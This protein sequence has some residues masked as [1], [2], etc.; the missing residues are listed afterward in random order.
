MAP[1][2]K[3]CAGDATTVKRQR[4]VMSLSSKIELLDWF[5]RGETTASIG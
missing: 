1:K 2:C 3:T 4:K 5:A